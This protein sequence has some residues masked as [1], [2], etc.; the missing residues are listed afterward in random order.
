[1]GRLRARYLLPAAPGIGLCLFLFLLCGREEPAAVG[2]RMT[3]RRDGAPLYTS[4]HHSPEVMAA[5]LTADLD[6]LGAA[7]AG[8]PA[9]RARP[10]IRAF[11]ENKKIDEKLVALLRREMETDAPPEEMRYTRLINALYA[12]LDRAD[13]GGESKTFADK[14]IMAHPY[15][16][17]LYG[18]IVAGL[19]E[20]LSGAEIRVKN[21]RES[22]ASPR[23]E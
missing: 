10:L 19:G 8:L 2:E 12:L 18:K 17:G 3:A 14:R 5:D 6:E 11:I 7:L 20:A 16:R 1:M 13:P 9:E 22:S 23:Q 15:M 21:P 4:V